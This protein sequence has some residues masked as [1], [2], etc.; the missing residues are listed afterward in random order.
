M[1]TAPIARI[2]MPLQSEEIKNGVVADIRQAGAPQEVCDLIRV[3]LN[4]TCSLNRQCYSKFTI[5]WTIQDGRW[6]VDYSLDDFGRLTTGIIGGEI[7]DAALALSGEIDP[8]PPDTFRRK[9]EQPVPAAQ[10][11]KPKQDDGMG[12]TLAHKS[13]GKKKT[14]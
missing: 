14:V 5:K 4:R 13:G 12:M 10:V 11:V 7:T 6:S 1:A 3:G 2:P 9:T 8:M